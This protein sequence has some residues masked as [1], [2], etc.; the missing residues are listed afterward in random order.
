M[1]RNYAGML[2]NKAAMIAAAQ[3]DP[4]NRPY[5]RI[6]LKCDEWHEGCKAFPENRLPRVAD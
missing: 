2:S 6:L 1:I 4:E 3:V 5:T